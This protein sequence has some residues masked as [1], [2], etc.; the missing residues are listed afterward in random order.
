[1]LLPFPY[2]DQSGTKRRPVLILSTDDYNLRRTDLIVAPITS[3]VTGGQPDD[4]VLNDWT[5][6]GLLK[7]SAVK[8]VLGTVEQRLVVRR[9]GRLS[10]ADLH[11]VE[12]TIGTALGLT[13]PTSP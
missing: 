13:A 5:A 1:V 2:T 12:L 10:A 9:L 7:P 3:N 4:R 11:Q 8:A 6:A